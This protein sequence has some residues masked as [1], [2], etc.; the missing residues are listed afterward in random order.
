MSESSAEPAGD[1]HTDKRARGRRRRTAWLIV[2]LVISAAAVVLPHLDIRGVA[3]IPVAQALVPLGAIALLVLAA[4][5]SIARA[6]G[7]ALVLIAGAI[8]SGLPALTPVSLAETCETDGSLTVLSFNAKLAAADPAELAGLIRTT[9]SDIVVLLETDEAL[10]ESLLSGDPGASDE[11]G[12]GLEDM[13]P[14]RT[15]EVSAGGAVGSVILSAYPLSGEEDIPGSEFDQVSAI[16]TLPAGTDGQGADAQGADVRVAAVHPPP[17]VWQPNGWYSGI[18]AIDRWVDETPDERLIV[19]GDL[20]ASFA[21]PVLRRM[22]SGLRSGSEAAG[23]FPWP[24]WPEE[25]IVPAFTAIDH[26][27]ARGAE[28]VGWSSFAVT[29]SDHRAVVA[30]WDLCTGAGD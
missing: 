25:K 24:T 22:A 14:H 23:P 6:W 15:R 29:G 3:A 11:A 19:A 7:A 27:F 30:E 20:N 4:A 8:L 5:S 1:P 16:A 28:P 21:H 26:V 2:A 13:L 18:E 9:E 12:D 17:P 10:I